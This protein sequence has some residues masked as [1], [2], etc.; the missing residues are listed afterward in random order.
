MLLWKVYL[1]QQRNQDCEFGL[2]TSQKHVLAIMDLVIVIK[3]MVKSFVRIGVRE[4]CVCS[5]LSA[6]F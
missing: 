2:P 5:V 6:P 3:Y 4:R 1:E